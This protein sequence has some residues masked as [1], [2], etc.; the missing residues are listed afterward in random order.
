MHRDEE[1]VG[2]EAVHLDE[3]VVVGRGAVDDEEDEVA[4]L[5][6][7]GP[8]VELLRVFDGQRVEAE[9]FAQ[10]VE[11]LGLRPFEVEPEEAA[12]CKELDDRF[13]AELDLA[14]AAVVADEA[15][16]SGGRWRFSSAARVLARRAPQAR[17]RRSSSGAS[18][19]RPLP[20]STLLTS[21]ANAGGSNGFGR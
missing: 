21:V 14:R 9:G 15:E 1:A 16:R 3:A 13:P 8:L 19:S 18:R 12:A 20:A 5:V 7:L 4:V 17:R 11:V 10:D 6:E 2:V